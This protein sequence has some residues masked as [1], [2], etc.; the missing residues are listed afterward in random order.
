MTLTPM[1]ASIGTHNLKTH[2]R[3]AL[4]K[5]TPLRAIENHV[6]FNIETADAQTEFGLMNPAEA[7]RH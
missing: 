1:G 7:T 3:S 4:Q 6:F 5:N 2:L